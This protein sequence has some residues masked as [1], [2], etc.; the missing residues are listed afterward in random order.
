MDK[1]K[2]IAAL[3]KINELEVKDYFYLSD[4]FDLVKAISN[5]VLY[6]KKMERICLQCYKKY[7]PFCDSKQ[8]YCSYVCMQRASIERVKQKKQL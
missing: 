7:N 3:K 8:K 2:L 6:P 1:V 5:E 4:Y